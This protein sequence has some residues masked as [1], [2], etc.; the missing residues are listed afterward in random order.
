[1]AP[2]KRPDYEIR[3]DT[4]GTFSAG[5]II[6]DIRYDA[7]KEEYDIRLKEWDEGIVQVSGGKR[8][9][10]RSFLEEKRYVVTPEYYHYHVRARGKKVDSAAISQKVKDLGM[11]FLWAR[12]IGEVP[13]EESRGR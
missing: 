9:L 11:K 3:L 12:V 7:V 8:E 4:A 2:R 1:M 10:I 5:Q 6:P 13:P